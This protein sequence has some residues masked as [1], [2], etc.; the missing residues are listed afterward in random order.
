MK[1]KKKTIR[2]DASLAKEI[3]DIAGV[4]GV[5]HVEASKMLVKKLK[6]KQTTKFYHL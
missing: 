6:E 2:V 5:T 1:S 4:Y 3:E